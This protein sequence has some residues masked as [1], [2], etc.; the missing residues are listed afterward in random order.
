MAKKTIVVYVSGKPVTEPWIA[1]NVPA[2]VQQFYQGERGGDAI[3]ALVL[4]DESPS[5]RL[6]VGIP[7]SVATREYSSFDTSCSSS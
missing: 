6:S 7:R 2:V 1:K 5:G 3:A 4:G